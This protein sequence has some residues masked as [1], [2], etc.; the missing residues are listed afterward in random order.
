MIK[1]IGFYSRAATSV[2]KSRSGGRLA[3]GSLNAGVAS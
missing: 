1:A 2:G 3:L